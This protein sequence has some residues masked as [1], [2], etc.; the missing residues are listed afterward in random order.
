MTNNNKMTDKPLDCVGVQAGATGKHDFKELVL[1]NDGI[2]FRL[3]GDGKPP[4]I[5]DIDSYDVKI[6]EHPYEKP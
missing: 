3:I 6:T 1:K 4:R 2:Y 5:E